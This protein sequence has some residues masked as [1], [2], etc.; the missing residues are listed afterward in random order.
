MQNRVLGPGEPYGL[1]LDVKILPEYL[2]DDGYI[3]Y[4]IGKWH[5]GDCMKRYLPTY[6]GFDYH[7]GYWEGN[8]DHYEHTMTTVSAN[9]P[10]FQLNDVGLNELYTSTF[11]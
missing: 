4:A 6:R 8:Q 5:L 11:L 7:F 1:P 3:N 10:N 9:M 2:K